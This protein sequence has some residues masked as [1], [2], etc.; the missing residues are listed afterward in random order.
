[1][2]WLQ[3]VVIVPLSLL[4]TAIPISIGGWGVRESAFVTGF[5]LVG[6]SASDA[7]VLSVLFGLLNFLVRLPGALI[8]LTVSN[9]ERPVAGKAIGEPPPMGRND[10]SRNMPERHEL[11]G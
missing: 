3:C 11:P 10:A 1:V 5:G 8:W 4:A 9:R 2:T 6:V 7:L